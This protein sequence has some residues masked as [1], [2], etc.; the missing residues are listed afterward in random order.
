MYEAIL[1]SKV[2]FPTVIEYC[3]EKV[4]VSPRARLNIKKIEDLTLPLAN[5]LV[6]KKLI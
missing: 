1:I 4:V 6:L 5:G 3:G 2:E